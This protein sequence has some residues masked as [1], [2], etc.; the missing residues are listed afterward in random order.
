[1]HDRDIDGEHLSR[2]HVVEGDDFGGVVL[3]HDPDSTGA[4]A[5]SAAC[6]RSFVQL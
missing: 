5:A 4:E 3:A 6:R 2:A 1:V